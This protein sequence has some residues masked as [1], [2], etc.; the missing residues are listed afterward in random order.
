MNL[1]DELHRRLFPQ[2]AKQQER[3]MSMFLDGVHLPLEIQLAR[4]QESSSDLFNKL[5]TS[6]DYVQTL[7]EYSDSDR[8]RDIEFNYQLYDTNGTFSGATDRNLDYG[9]GKRV[10]I[11]SDTD[12]DVIQ[13]A[14]R[15]VRNTPVL[16]VRNFRQM[17]LDYSIQGEMLFIVW[18]S[19]LTKLSTITRIPTQDITIV[20]ADELTKVVPALYILKSQEGDIVYRDWRTMDEVVDAYLAENEDAVYA[21]D[22]ESNTLGLEH[23]AVWTVGSKRHNKSGRGQPLLNVITKNVE[24][25]SQFDDQRFAVSNRAASYTEEYGVSGTNTDLQTFINRE[26]AYAPPGS[27]LVGNDGVE[28]KWN[29]NPTGANSERFN[30]HIW[31][32]G[33]AAATGQNHAMGGIPSALSNRSVLDKLMEIFIEYIE[34]MQNTIAD[35]IRDVFMIVVLVHNNVQLI[36][37][38]ELLLATVDRN[39]IV[40]LDTPVNIDLSLAMSYVLQQRDKEDLDDEEIRQIE[41]L[42]TIIY[43]KFGIN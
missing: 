9:L 36:G 6:S 29:N 22:L 33:I 24:F 23:L 12:E 18:F 31:Y 1:K 42:E 43:Q 14:L 10:M 19:E 40:T 27:A 35:T 20:W 30:Q 38:P 7:S 16:G 8:L 21:T 26:S 2:E 11:H 37:T 28:R 4:L 3:L 15:A 39:I 5:I 32:Q 41:A 34:N 17:G 25:F 13:E